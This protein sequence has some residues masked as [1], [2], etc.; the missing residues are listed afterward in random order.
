MECGRKPADFELATGLLKGKFM[1]RNEKL[2][3]NAQS[4][5]KKMTKEEA[6]LWYQ[7]L[8]RCQPRFHRQFVI[9]NYIAD[10]YCHKAKLIVELDGSQHCTPEEI[11]YDQK[12]T[13]YLQ[14]QGLK[15]LRFSNFDVMRQ[16]EAVCEVIDR[17]IGKD[18][19][20]SKSEK[21]Y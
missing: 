19:S 12:R 1:E 20:C 13:D 7:F 11:Q 10:F 17:A 16:F 8:S 15:V 3:Q 4:L 9:G 18:Q 6:K 21:W 2:T 14:S 5:R